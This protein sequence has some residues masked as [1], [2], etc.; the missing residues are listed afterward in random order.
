MSQEERG[1][2]YS[3][4]QRLE[5]EGIA[6]NPRRKSEELAKDINKSY[7]DIQIKSAASISHHFKDQ[8]H[9]LSLM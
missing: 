3:H 2:H 7:S 9:E 8:S 4:I 1:H 5:V 6:S